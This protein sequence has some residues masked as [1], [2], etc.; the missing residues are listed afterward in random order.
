M[1]RGIA[2][3]VV[4]GVVVS[5]IAAIAAPGAEVNDAYTGLRNMALGM[6]P[7]M[8]GLS[9]S[10]PNRPYAV[11]TDISLENG[12]A[13]VVA[14]LG[15][16]ASIYLSSGGGYIGGEG[17]ANVRAAAKAAVEAADAALSEMHP[18]KEHPLPEQGNVTFYVLTTSGIMTATS[19]ESALRDT[20]QPLGHLYDAAQNVITQYRSLRRPK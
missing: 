1:K 9:G 5:A 15:G 11:I 12:V 20:S 3:A 7:D 18:T 10:L 2:A 4:F 13:T 6:T 14:G 8:L 16:Q 19:S 17:N